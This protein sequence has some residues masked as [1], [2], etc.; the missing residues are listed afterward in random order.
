MSFFFLSYARDDH[1]FADHLGMKLAK[2]GEAEKLKLW[3]DVGDIKAGEEWRRSI[4]TALHNC[5]ALLVVMSPR[6][7]QS[8][9]VTYEWATAMGK[10]KPILPLL[11]GRCDVHPKL[12]PIHHFDFTT[13]GKEEWGKLIDRMKEIVDERDEFTS[14]EM[15]DGQEVAPVSATDG[16]AEA[17]NRVLAYLN[18]RGYR[19][20]S[21]ERVRDKID[22]GYSD[23]FLEGVIRSNPHLFRKGWLKGS[24]PGFK[25]I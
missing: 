15:V 3:V 8:S 21:F 19:L 9:Y 20:V 6:S 2:D 25:K 23:A 16:E 5:I 18:S 13:Q 24:K 17:A 10:E 14:V 12:E 11:I 22:A 4:D 7:A 1:L